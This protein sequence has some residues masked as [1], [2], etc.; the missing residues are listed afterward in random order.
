[1]EGM[2]SYGWGIVDKDGCPVWGMHFKTFDRADEV[3]SGL[4]K[5][6]FRTFAPYNPV[7]LFYK[8]EQS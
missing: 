7:E 4:E 5:S 1:M 6:A 2:K 3:A 8:E